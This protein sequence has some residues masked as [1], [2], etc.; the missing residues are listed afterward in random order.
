MAVLEA[1]LCQIYLDV[2]DVFLLLCWTHPLWTPTFFFFS[3]KTN[4]WTEGMA[5]ILEAIE[6]N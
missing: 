3:L 2:K 4:T 5:D 6:D 1:I